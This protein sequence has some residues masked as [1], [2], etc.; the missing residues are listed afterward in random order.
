VGR[1]EIDR[2]GL[3]L[4][5][6]HERSLRIRYDGVELLR[7][8]YAPRE[9][10]AESPRPYLHPV[11]TLQGDVV[12]AYRPHDHVWHKGISWSLP[13]VGDENFWGGPTYVDGSGYV[14]LANNGSMEH[15]GFTW[16]EADRDRVKVAHE[17]DWMT[18][19][20]HPRI[21]EHRALAVTV[22]ETAWTLAFESAMTNVTDAPIA[23]GSP[24]TRGRPAAGYGGL[25]WRG[26]HAFTGGRVHA[27]SRSGGDDLMGTRHRWLAFTGRHDEHGRQSTLVFVDDPERADGPT[28]WFVRSSE[29]PGVCPAPF[30]STETVLAEGETLRL[31]YA[32]TVADGARTP[33]ELDRLA[34]A[35]LTVL[36]A[37]SA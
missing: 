18:Q 31:R 14:S 2:S 20:G 10:Q 13:F 8:V 33:A 21:R 28:E 23:F 34:D 36:K 17:L 5:L 4:D 25:F 35:G 27:P 22:D 9:E 19:S 6:E 11:R 1:E 16:A 7:Y 26:P 3:A 24:S 37:L 15:R 30:Y 32:V 12:T 29:F